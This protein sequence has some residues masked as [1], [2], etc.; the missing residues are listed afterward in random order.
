M[1]TLRAEDRAE[2]ETTQAPGP[3]GARPRAAG[4][5]RRRAAPPAGGRY[6]GAGGPPRAGGRSAGTGPW[7]APRSLPTPTPPPGGDEGRRLLCP[8]IEPPRRRVVGANEAARGSRGGGFA[9][10]PPEQHGAE[11]ENVAAAVDPAVARLLLRR[12]V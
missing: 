11:G 3:A 6:A 4:A 2:D 10:R 1:L 7:G 9:P 8:R 12:H 5:A